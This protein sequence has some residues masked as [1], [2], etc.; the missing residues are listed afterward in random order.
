MK[1]AYATTLTHGDAYAPGIEAL[2]RSLRASGTRAPMVLM[3]TADVPAR[4]RDRLA[5]Q[6]W[7]IREIEP[8]K[9]PTPARQQLFP[10]FDKV[11][12]KLRA[13][14]LLDFDRVV[15]LDADTVV[16]R[17]IDEL[18]ER[19]EL[20]AAP[21]FLLPHHFNSG[22][23]VLEPAREK[24]ARMLGALAAAP[25]YD[26]GDQGFLNTFF[27]DWYTAAGDRRLPTWYNLPN[28]IYQFMRG[29]EGTRAQVEREA[30]VLHYMVQ[31]PWQSAST[32]TGGSEVWWN[33][34]LGAH[35]E[36]DTPWKRRL[37]ALEDRSFDRA[38]AAFVG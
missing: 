33:A 3:V 14:E 16:L 22:V 11:F 19:S 18:F 4:A 2:G 10:R 17:N 38:V 15:L 26:G 36:L 23:M 34:Y 30:K 20:T 24:L 13:W 9:N 1:T 6:G 25:S 29:H 35:P 37:H 12:T 21:D 32:V 8:V 27:G 7:F 31:K 5:A 28:F